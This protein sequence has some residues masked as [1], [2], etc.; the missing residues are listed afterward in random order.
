M[1]FSAIISALTLAVLPAQGA[2]TAP[3]ETSA[4]PLRRVA[5][6]YPAAC[7]PAAG[8]PVGSAQRVTI[9]YDVSEDGYPQNVRVR[10][11]TDPCFEEAAVA[12]V[13]A[14]YFSPRKIRGRAAEQL[15][16][17]TTFRFVLNEET[18]IDDIDAR[19]LDRKPPDYPDKCIRKAQSRESVF[20]EFDVTS[21]GRT[22]N[23]RVVDSTNVCFEKAALKAVEAWI[24]HPKTVDGRPA[25]RPG[26][27]T[28]ITFELVNDGW[29]KPS[30]AARAKVWRRLVSIQQDIR[31]KRS[32]AVVLAD[33]A[34]LEA[35]FGNEFT[36]TE[37]VSFHHLRASARLE[38]ADYAG[39]LDDLEFVL[40]IKPLDKKTYQA[41]EDAVEQLKTIVAAQEAAAA[42]EEAFK[43]PDADAT[44]QQ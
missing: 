36:P 12:S 43:P 15:D 44:P 18:A 26:V 5:P 14:S 23:I 40:R 30:P 35:E 17:E 28:A 2:H 32:A 10:E 34:D 21:E 38:K 9:A 41:I 39:A 1:R 13:R 19:P 11:S 20:I 29:G 4:K 33:L 8:E 37:L 6:A 3:D 42:S 27:Q 24:Y 25:P 16:M 31:K 22:D 7:M